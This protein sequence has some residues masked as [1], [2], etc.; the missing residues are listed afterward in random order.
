MDDLDKFLA[1]LK[2]IES[3][4]AYNKVALTM[5]QQIKKRIFTDG[6]NAKMSSMGKYKPSTLRTRS[7]GKN[8]ARVPQSK[9]IILEFTGQ[10]RRDF[11]PIKQKGVIIGSGFKQKINSMKRKWVEKRLRQKIFA[12]SI[13]ESKKFNKLLQ[14]EVT[15]ILKNG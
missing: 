3:G 1:A 8:R 5:H 9:N 10:M 6:L 4:E 14:E 7:S 11:A 12:M 13:K 2:K 15:K